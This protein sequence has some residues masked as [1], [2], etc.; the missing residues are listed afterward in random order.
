MFLCLLYRLFLSVIGVVVFLATSYDVFF[1]RS[2]HVGR[3]KSDKGSP[4]TAYRVYGDKNVVAPAHLSMD[5][6]HIGRDNAGSCFVWG[7]AGKL[8]SSASN[9]T[10]TRCIQL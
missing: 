4:I 9:R 6:L 8:W 7:S 3:V 1:R 10:T 5:T 2:S